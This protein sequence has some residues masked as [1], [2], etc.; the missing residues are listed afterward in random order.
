[1]IKKIIEKLDK[2]P[3]LEYVNKFLRKKG[4]ATNVQDENNLSFK[5]YDMNWDLNCE[6]GRLG[7]RVFFNLGDDIN[8][9]YMYQAVNRFN[10]E[11]WIVKA[12]IDTYTPKEE[13]GDKV[14]AKVISSIIFSFESF[15]YSQSA[16]DKMYEF[17]IYAMTDGMDFHRKCYTELIKEAKSINNT[18]PIGFH[19]TSVHEGGTSVASNNNRPKIG[20]IQ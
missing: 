5:L 20:F 3:S 13:N 17:A 7:L 11:R 18:S 10:K 15:C 19:T 8:I 12:F 16:F 9:S 1:M 4:I 2:A 14:D 6:N